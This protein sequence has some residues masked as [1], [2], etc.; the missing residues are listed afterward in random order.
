MHTETQNAMRTALRQADAIA[1]VDGRYTIRQ[2]LR[3]AHDLYDAMIR[4][5]PEERARRNHL[6]DA[7]F[8]PPAARP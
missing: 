2:R 7:V 5:Q 3:L 4:L 8:M 1:D 6:I